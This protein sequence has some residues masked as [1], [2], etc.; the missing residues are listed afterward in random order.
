VSRREDHSTGG[1]LDRLTSAAPGSGE[2]WRQEVVRGEGSS[3]NR[4]LMSVVVL[5][6]VVASI[7]I[8]V[9]MLVWWL[10]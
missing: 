5:V 4:I 2:R 8:L 7:A 1:G 9:A 3:P 10:A 6:G